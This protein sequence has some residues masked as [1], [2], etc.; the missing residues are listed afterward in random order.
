M[1]FAL[2]LSGQDYDRFTRTFA[3]LARHG[4]TDWALTGGLAVELHMCRLEIQPLMRT[5]NDIDLVANS[6]EFPPHALAKDFLFRHVHPCAAP[7]QTML[8]C[9]DTE[10]ALRVDIFSPYG[11]AMTRTSLQEFPTCNLR[12]ISLEDLVSRE[13]SLLMDLA[14][15]VSVASK[16]ALDFRRLSEFADAAKA[17]VAWRDYR[18]QDHPATFAAVV[19]LVQQLIDNRPDLLIVP[20]YSMDVNATCAR[21]Q[22]ILTFPLADPRVVFS[23]LGYC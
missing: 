13:A 1:S 16:F 11:A 7:G 3:K 6:F 18:K 21:C 10:T 9:V 22:N 12:L 15:N 14:R 5:L 8:Q 4:L 19:P 23:V 17:E 2:F 20:E